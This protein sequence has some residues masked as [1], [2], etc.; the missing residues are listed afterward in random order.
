MLISGAAT[1]KMDFADLS[2]YFQICKPHCLY[3]GTSSVLRVYGGP[4][5]RLI[6][7]L[8]VRY[9]VGHRKSHLF[10]YGYSLR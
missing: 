6:L 3:L 1:E 4:L 8:H 10:L 7:R 5:E 9:E 2:I